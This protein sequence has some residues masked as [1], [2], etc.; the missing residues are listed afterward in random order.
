M[1][2]TKADKKWWGQQG[3]LISLWWIG[4]RHRTRAHTLSIKWTSSILSREPTSPKRRHNRRPTRRTTQTGSP[5]RPAWPTPRRRAPKWQ[6]NRRA[7]AAWPPIHTKWARPSQAAAAVWPCSRRHRPRS[8]R[9]RRA[10]VAKVKAR[11]YSKRISSFVLLIYCLL[12]LFGEVYK[13]KV[14]LF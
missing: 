13:S 8:P 6:A 2:I 1:L 10:A 5:L 14:S 7:A 4:A 3:Q 11:R 9:R 12:E